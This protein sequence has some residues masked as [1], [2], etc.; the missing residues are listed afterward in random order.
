[1]ANRPTS[2]RNRYVSDAF[3]SGGRPSQASPSSAPPRR[4][5]SASG[6]MRPGGGRRRFGAGER[7]GPD[8]SGRR[9]VG[10]VDVG[11]RFV[12][13]SI[14]VDRW[15]FVTGGLGGLLDRIPVDVVHVLVEV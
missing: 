9:G 2:R 6:E 10:P 14:D 1:M 15:C 5:A 12:I 7:S 3:A 4:A 13:G 11:V 8:T